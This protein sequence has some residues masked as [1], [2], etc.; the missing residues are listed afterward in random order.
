MDVKWIKPGRRVMVEIGAGARELTGSPPFVTTA[1]VASPVEGR[2]DAWWLLLDIPG[3]PGMTDLPQQYTAS[4]IL[5][6]SFLEAD[7]MANADA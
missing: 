4:E 3:P 1:L 7:R 5:G 2:S 6:L